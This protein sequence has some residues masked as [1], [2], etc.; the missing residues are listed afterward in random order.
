M[1]VGLC[2]PVGLVVANSRTVIGDAVAWWMLLGV[3]SLV[4]FV[5]LAVVGSL[6]ASALRRARPWLGRWLG[7]I[8]ATAAILTYASFVFSVVEIVV[9]PETRDPNSWGPVLT[10]GAAALVAL[11]YAIGIAANTSVLVR[12]WLRSGTFTDPVH[13]GTKGASP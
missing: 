3:F 1:F 5:P 8:G 4:A 6:G 12:L 9:A 10:P 2:L 13:D 7:S 11:P